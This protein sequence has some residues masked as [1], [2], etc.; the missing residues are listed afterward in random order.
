LG[1]EIGRM[2]DSPTSHFNWRRPATLLGLAV[3]LMHGYFLIAALRLGTSLTDDSIQYLTIAENWAAHG[4]FSQSYTTPW[5]PDLQRTPGYPA[6][7]LALGMNV[8]LILVVQHLLV[9]LSGW[10]LYQLVAEAYSKRMGKVAAWLY[11]L[12][13]Y[14]VIFASFVLSETL[15]ICIG[16]VAAWALLRFWR[17]EGWP[18]LA[19]GMGMLCLA[20]LVR[21]VA[22][23]LVG[24]VGLAALGS[25]LLHQRQKLAHVAALVA[26]PLVVLGPWLWRNHTVSGKWEL[27]NMGAMGML[28][29]RI[30]GLE[31][32]RQGKGNAEHELY[33]AG[34]SIVGSEWGL[35]AIRDYPAGKETHETERL[36]AGMVQQTLAFYWAHPGQAMVFQAKCLGQMFTGVGY[37]WAKEITHS[38]FVALVAAG[39][40][41]LCNCLMYLGLLLAVYRRRNWRVS[42]RLAFWSITVIL[43]VSSA[44]WSDGRYRAV[45]D[46]LMCMLLAFVLWNYEQGEQRISVIPKLQVVE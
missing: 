19:L 33:M 29:G 5:T 13:P 14:P 40:Q 11:L 25:V 35:A 24:L 1:H 27:S 15:F 21:P 38:R 45:V 43:V 17:R 7:L 36:H 4:S 10:L 6:F 20:T 16:L 31:A 32:S 37:G 44:A 9:L 18:W 3:L 41:V 2:T 34:D 12:Q 39:I 23:P 26:V 22:A 30:G 42:E 46:P 28:H 8:P